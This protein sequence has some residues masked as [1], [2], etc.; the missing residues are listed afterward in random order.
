M[1]KSVTL[2]EMRNRPQWVCWK[3]EERDGRKTKIPKNPHT[4][5][6]A[7]S[8]DST[9]WGTFHDAIT[10][11]TRYCFDGIGIMLTNG[12][13]GIDIDALNHGERDEKVNPL[14]KEV[15]LMFEGT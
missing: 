15:C 6:N 10:A 11:Q 4:G 13:C 1:T 8:N 14:E 5:G 7:K 3:L 2:D 9:T 12:L